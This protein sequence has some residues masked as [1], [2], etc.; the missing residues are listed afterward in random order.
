MSES[1]ELFKFQDIAIPHISRLLAVHNSVLCVAP[2]GSGKTVIMSAISQ[3]YVRT[4]KNNK[5]CIFVHREELFNQ[6]R[7]KLLLEIICSDLKLNGIISQG[8][9]QDTTYI[10]PNIRVYVIMIETFFSRISSESFASFF[11]DIKLY[12]IDEAHRNDFIKIFEYFPNAKRLGF[13]ATPLSSKK[14]FPLKDYYEVMFEIAK[15]SQLQLLNEENPMSGVVPNDLYHFSIVD[16]RKF[17]K[18]QDGEYNE[19]QISSEFSQTYQI[20][21]TIK[22]YFTQGKG[23]K[24]LCFDADIDHSKKMVEAFRYHGVNARHVNGSPKDKYGKKSWRKDCLEWLRH[25]PDAVLNNVMLLGTGFD[26]KSVECVIPNR[27]IGLFSTWTQML[28][29]AAR[30]YQYPDLHFKTSYKTLDCGN[31]AC[32]TG[33]NH[34]DCNQDPDWQDYFDNPNKPSREGVGGMKACPECGAVNSVASVFCR[35]Y[36]ED[37]L[38]GSLVECGYIFPQTQKEEDSIPREMIKFFNVNIDVKQ[39]IKYFVNELGKSYG[40]VYYET[41]NQISNLANKTIESKY[42]D[43]IQL[44]YFIDL[45]VSKIKELGKVSGK[46]THKESVKN[47]LIKYLQKYNFIVNVSEVEEIII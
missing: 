40:S 1:I 13:T 22:A 47:D 6:T 35:G 19:K 2:G 29:R 32:M 38:S 27:P 37:W 33:G 36:K 42:L 30:A 44:Q 5:I 7:E 20:D 21:N 12:F 46:R 45:A 34:G 41:L 14:K 8:I 3:R 9:N 23:L 28:V 16:L 15:I 25:T 11:K 4:N 31:N 39:N 17:K 24:T 43:S 18:S 26:E 10:D